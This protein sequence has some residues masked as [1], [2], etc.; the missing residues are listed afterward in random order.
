MEIVLDKNFFSDM[1]MQLKFSEFIIN[2]LDEQLTIAK[3][4]KLAGMCLDFIETHFKKYRQINFYNDFVIKIT[5]DETHVQLSIKLVIE[6]K[7]MELLKNKVSFLSKCD[8]EALYKIH[9]TLINE[10]YIEDQISFDRGDLAFVNLFI[11]RFTFDSIP[12]IEWN[13]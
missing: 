11:G 8:Q 4:S 12:L 6:S 2:Y 13:F 3:W 5:D 9:G 10:S 1:E 7:N